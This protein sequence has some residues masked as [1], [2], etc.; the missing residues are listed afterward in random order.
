VK[1]LLLEN[2]G[3]DVKEYNGSLG[4]D[5][6][7]NPRTPGDS[8]STESGDAQSTYFV[9]RLLGLVTSVIDN[10]YICLLLTGRVVGSVPPPILGNK[11]EA[12]RNQQDS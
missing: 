11:Q 2:A 3:I 9:D 10:S 4:S 12:D 6:L 1:K 5:D 8:M 7:L